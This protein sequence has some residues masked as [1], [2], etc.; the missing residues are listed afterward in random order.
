LL[1]L[2]Q[3]AFEEV[4][5]RD[6]IFQIQEF[7][8]HNMVVFVEVKHDAGSDFFRVYDFGVIQAE[9]D[10]LGLLIKM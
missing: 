10:G 8:A 7:N 1:P 2:L 9:I 5:A 3:E 4:D 6:S